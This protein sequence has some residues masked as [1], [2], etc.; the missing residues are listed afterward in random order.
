M[1]C[2]DSRLLWLRTSHDVVTIER[3][4]STKV[5]QRTASMK[6]TSN[7]HHY[8]RLLGSANY[9]KQCQRRLKGSFTAVTRVQIPS[10]TPTIHKPTRKTYFLPGH[11]CYV[12]QEF[13][14]AWQSCAGMQLATA[15]VFYTA[16][17]TARRE[18]MRL[19]GSKCFQ[20]SL[21]ITGFDTHAK[22]SRSRAACS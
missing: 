7:P 5:R 16:L 13:G 21:H 22:R 20:T 10:G 8:W 9:S 2:L 15:T 17:H 3:E 14:E 1:E 12:S 18:S 6:T 19:H 4:N 11:T